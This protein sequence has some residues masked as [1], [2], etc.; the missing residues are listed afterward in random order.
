MTRISIRGIIR[1]GRVEVDGPIG[2][3]DGS[4]VVITGDP[5][6]GPAPP[7][8]DDRSPTPEEI[9]ATL[10]VMDAIEPLEL[11]AEE[12]SAWEAERRG[13]RDREKTHFREHAEGLRGMWE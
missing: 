9:A 8:E 13:R 3:P 2:L 1:G 6:G 11:S 5:R 12:Q 7:S 4:E 10:A